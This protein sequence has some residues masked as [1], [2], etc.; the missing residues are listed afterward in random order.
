MQ[1]SIN[2][3]S[4][5]DDDDDGGGGGNGIIFGLLNPKNVIFTHCPLEICT[6]YFHLSISTL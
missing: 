2:D 3:D 4:H 6:Y 1:K 5:Y